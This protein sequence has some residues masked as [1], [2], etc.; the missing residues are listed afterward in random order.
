MSEKNDLLGGA[1]GKVES[2]VMG[3]AGTA[4]AFSV[5]V[6]TA[7]IVG[8][9]GVLSVGSV[10]YCGLIMFGIMLAFSHLA[11]MR[12]HAGA[13]Y[14]W[15]GKVFGP[16]WGFFAGWGLLVSSVVF[17]VSAT[18]PA[19]TSTLVLIAPDLSENVNWVTFV[20]AL[21]LT[22]ITIIVTK[23]IKHASYT[24]LILTAIESIILLALIVGAFL[25]YGS[26]P[27]H[28]PELSWISLFSFTPSTFASGALTAI[29][30]YWGWDVTMNLGEETK[31]KAAN[32]GAFWSMVNLII[33]FVIM[34]VVVL[35]VMTD[36][37]IAKAN[38]N[39]LYAIADKLFPKPWNYI[40]VVSTILSTVGTIETQIIQFSRCL[41][42]MARDNAMHPRYS[43]IHP[44]WQ[45]P[46]VAT[47]VI[48]FLGILLLF[49]SSYMPSIQAILSS[50]IKAI[51]I[52][53][54]FYMSL[55]GFACAWHYRYKKSAGLV[56][57][58][59]YV[60]WPLTSAIF[61]VFIALYSLPTFDLTTKLVGIGGL[62]IGFIPFIIGRYRVFGDE[63]LKSANTHDD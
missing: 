41:F 61:M 12:P 13:T 34:M 15:V 11:N 59:S 52:Q 45:T 21:W 60:I 29:F 38:T 62:L 25:Q 57:S 32:S 1:L 14:A 6:T 53:I 31:T 18:I 7:T 2:T 51:G 55:A 26:N 8:T 9:V 63:S 47:V 19:S 3:V 27:V 24:Q 39:V 16:A 48:W 5:A 40:A 42:A 17:M 22:V 54:C 4:P 23:G 44:E 46:W 58:F 35:I 56:A 37:E 28:P 36:S 50:S 20:S 30:F 49:S 10:L 33:F 43:K